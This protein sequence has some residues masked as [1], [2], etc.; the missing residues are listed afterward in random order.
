METMKAIASR[1][2]CSTYTG[3]QITDDELQTILK[4]AN[5]AP[6]GMGKFEEVKLTV[7]QNKDLLN[8]FDSTGAKFFGNPESHP[9]YGAPTVILVSAINPGNAHTFVSYCNAACIVEK[10]GTSSYGFRS[11]KCIHF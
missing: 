5:A 4:A 11:G 6:I 2:S 10:H 1:Q 7:I 9:L 3:E 8:K